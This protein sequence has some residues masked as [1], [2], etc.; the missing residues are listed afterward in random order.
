MTLSLGLTRARL[1]LK[2]TPT[3]AR[4]VAV[5]KGEEGERKER[6]KEGGEEGREEGR[7]RKRRGKERGER[8]VERERGGSK[9]RLFVAPDVF[10]LTNKVGSGGK[11]MRQRGPERRKY[12]VH[13][14]EKADQ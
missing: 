2:N 11:V 9:C 5:R 1:W 12:R 7:G 8:R 10:S 4:T 14:E 3:T 6:E 13:R